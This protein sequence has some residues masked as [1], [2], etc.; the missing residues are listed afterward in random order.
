MN[1]SLTEDTGPVTFTFTITATFTAENEDEAWEQWAEWLTDPN[2][3]EAGTVASL[4]VTCAYCGVPIREVDDGIW[5]DHTMGD[6]CDGDDDLVN[7]GGAHS[8]VRVTE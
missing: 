5:E 7:E 3:V 1:H 4:A 8:P 2:H 6:V